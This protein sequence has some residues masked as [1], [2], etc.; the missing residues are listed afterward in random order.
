MKCYGSMENVYPSP[1]MRTSY[2][3]YILVN[4][5]HALKKDIVNIFDFVDINKFSASVEQDN[6]YEQWLKSIK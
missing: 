6:Y 2:L 1:M 3:A 5:K 4:G